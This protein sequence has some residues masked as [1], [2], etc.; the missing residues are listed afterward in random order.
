MFKNTWTD[1]FFVIK[2][3]EIILSLICY[4]KISVCKE[5]NIKRH[6]STNMVNAKIKFELIAYIRKKRYD[7]S[8]AMF[9]IPK[10]YS[11]TATNISFMIEEVIVKRSKP[12]SDGDF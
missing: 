3:N 12:L 11:E 7:R 10:D 5:Y 1:A 2:Q 6:Y 8:T 9:K 4:E